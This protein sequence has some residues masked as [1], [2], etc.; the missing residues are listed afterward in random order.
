MYAVLNY[1]WPFEGKREGDVAPHENEF[2]TPALE[3]PSLIKYK[4]KTPAR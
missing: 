2:D 3:A 1:I 4:N